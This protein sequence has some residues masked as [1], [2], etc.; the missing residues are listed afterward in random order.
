MGPNSS[1]VVNAASCGRCCH[2]RRRQGGPHHAPAR[3]WPNLESNLCPGPD[4]HRGTIR[5]NEQPHQAQD[6]HVLRL[7]PVRL[8]ARELRRPLAPTHL[9]LFPIHARSRLQCYDLAHVLSGARG[10]R[11]KAAPSTH[12]PIMTQ[13]YKLKATCPQCSASPE[14]K[15]RCLD[16]LCVVVDHRVTSKHAVSLDFEDG[17]RCSTAEGNLY[18]W[19]T[20]I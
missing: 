7:V 12:F 5:G 4:M 16:T 18:P 9:K 15:A 2:E 13:F 11:G 20:H 19:P 14:T 10:W 6:A 8:D 3:V 17:S 1:I